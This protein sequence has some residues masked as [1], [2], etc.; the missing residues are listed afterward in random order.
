MSNASAPSIIDAIYQYF[1]AC[2]LLTENRINVDYLPEDAKRGVEFS[3]DATPGTEIVKPYIRGGAECQFLF[4][5]R[6]VNDYGPD[7]WQNLSNSGFYDKLSAW[8]RQQSRMRK[9]PILP[10]GMQSLRIG[11]I[12][13]GYL[14]GTS[15][16]TAYYQI[17]CKLS[18]HRKGD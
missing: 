10:D 14:F 9:L 13:A 8:L 16:S 17:Q 5:L 12:S 7:Y 15:E 18:Y 2:P 6:S 4:T 3:I 1:S 11:A